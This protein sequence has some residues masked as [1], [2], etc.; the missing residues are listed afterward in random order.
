M[1]KLILI[2]FIWIMI[3]EQLSAGNCF[4]IMCN[5]GGKTIPVKKF[6]CDIHHKTK[7]QCKR[8]L[9]DQFKKIYGTDDLYSVQQTI[10]FRI[11]AAFG[12]NLTV[13]LDSPK[14]TYCKED[15]NIQKS[16]RKNKQKR[17]LEEE[18]KRERERLRFKAV[19]A[20][21]TMYGSKNCDY[22]M[23]IQEMKKIIKE[24]RKLF[25]NPIEKALE[26]GG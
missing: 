16:L 17:F 19:I 21:H 6:K 4:E 3:V 24:C 23:T 25:S 2:T 15:K 11:G 22:K 5:G 26:C 9:K 20:C 13:S 12:V 14:W 8:A 18:K 10:C 7:K 1:R